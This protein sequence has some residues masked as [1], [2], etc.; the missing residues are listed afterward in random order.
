M[1][2]KDVNSLRNVHNDPRV[3]ALTKV[4]GSPLYPPY[5]KYYKFVLFRHPFTRMVSAWRNKLLTVD[6]KINKYFYRNYGIPIIRLTRGKWAEAA[7]LK[8]QTGNLVTFQEFVA[9][10]K[11][12]IIDRHWMPQ[13]EICQPCNVDYNHVGFFEYLN[14]DTNHILDEV[15]SVK[16]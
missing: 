8:N 14:D 3:R 7:F 12:G 11:N 5:S 4:D 10:V 2:R 9:G 16:I 13:S 6:G 1:T 15:C